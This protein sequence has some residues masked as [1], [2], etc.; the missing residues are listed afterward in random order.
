MTRS[1]GYFGNPS[2]EIWNPDTTNDT[3]VMTGERR[4]P[5]LVALCG[6]RGPPNHTHCNRDRIRQVF[7]RKSF[8][9]TMRATRLIHVQS[10]RNETND[11]ID[12]SGEMSR[13]RR[14]RNQPWKHDR[15]G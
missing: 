12:Y 10:L 11:L 6:D 7:D 9:P 4:L 2:Q 8:V 15:I 5:Q 3:N 13:I 14:T 1:S